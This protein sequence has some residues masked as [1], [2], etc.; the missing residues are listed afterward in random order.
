[1]KKFAFRLERVLQLRVT[2]EQEQARQLADARREEE[3]CRGVLEAS[4]E[5]LRS[6]HEQMASIHAGHGVAG[7]LGNMSLPLEVLRA[8][9]DADAARHAAALQRLETARAAY[10]VAR[11]ERMAMERLRDQRRAAWEKDV[12]RHEQAA[13]DEVA[14][15]VSGAQELGA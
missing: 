3:S 13:L 11:Q 9:L 12:A 4:A 1:M 15:R 8:R 7:L 2:A 10:D 6:A 5:R 14:L